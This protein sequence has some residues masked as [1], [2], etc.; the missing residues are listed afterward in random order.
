MKSSHQRAMALGGVTTA[1][2]P[3]GDVRGK[4]CYGHECT[5]MNMHR[6]NNGKYYRVSIDC[7]YFEVAGNEL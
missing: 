5:R 3:K 6:K 7:Q 1:G 2:T 4:A